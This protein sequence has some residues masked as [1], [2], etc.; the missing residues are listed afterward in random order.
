[1]KKIINVITRI[2]KRSLIDHVRIFALGIVAFVIFPHYITIVLLL[3]FAI[4]ILIFF[5]SLSI[6]SLIACI[7]AL[8][9]KKISIAVF[10]FVVITTPMSSVTFLSAEF[11][12]QTCYLCYKGFFIQCDFQELE[13]ALKKYKKKYKEYPTTEFGLE[14]LSEFLTKIPKDP[15]GDSYY[16]KREKEGYMLKCLNVKSIYPGKSSVFLELLK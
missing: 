12:L 3:I 10:T 15:W 8:V 14:P 9:E 16:Y 2:S 6:K 5:A 1:M 4:P 7:Y 11:H 13:V